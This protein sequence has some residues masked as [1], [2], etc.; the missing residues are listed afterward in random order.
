MATLMQRT[1]D[2]R[3]RVMK[4]DPYA[5]ETDM[6]TLLA[7]HPHLLGA[8]AFEDEGERR[9]ILV[10]R[11]MSVEIEDTDVT[12]VGSV[13]HLFVDQEGV[14]VIVEVKRA[15]NTESRRK[16]VGQIL[17]YAANAP[18]HWTADVLR[19]AFETAPPGAGEQQRTPR[20]R[21][22][23]LLG[24]EDP[25]PDAFWKLVEQNLREGRLRIVFVLDRVPTALLRIVEFLNKHL[26]TVE[27]Y[28][29][30]VRRHIGGDGAPPIL[31]VSRRGVSA[32]DRSQ[33]SRTQHPVLTLDAWEERFH[34]RHGEDMLAAAKTII[35]WMSQRGRVFVTKSGDPS[36]GL[37]ITGPGIGR[38]PL[39]VKANGRLAVAFT[40]LMQRPEFADEDMRSATAQRILEIVDGNGRYGGST[41]DVTLEL[42]PLLDEEKRD[43]FLNEIQRLVDR[44]ENHGQ[45]AAGSA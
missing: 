17:D 22:A 29:L 21:L 31:E 14:P 4:E 23:W 28:A 27:T 37:Q 7:Q 1:G 24:T 19:S 26:D 20:E 32:S 16:I 8:D 6:Q 12:S 11:E 3:Y 33:A 5:A 2:G 30:E 9:W 35:D 10:R 43:R 40:Y 15:S 39:F 42:A 44:M 41:G 45:S 36:V 13:D 18:H 25:D 38:Y 34:G